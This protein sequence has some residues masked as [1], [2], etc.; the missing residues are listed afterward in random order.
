M[1][2]DG[3]QVISLSLVVILLSGGKADWDLMF[4]PPSKR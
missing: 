3:E 4:M 1:L 2:G